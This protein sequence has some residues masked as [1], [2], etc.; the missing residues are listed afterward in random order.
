[1]AATMDLLDVAKCGV[2][3]D[4]Y[5]DPRMLSCGHTYCQ[6]CLDPTLHA[7]QGKNGKFFQ[8]PECREETMSAN[9]VLSCALLLRRCTS[10]CVAPIR[11]HQ[12]SLYDH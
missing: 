3:L 7:I 5:T 2:C 10:Y 11:T 9:A 4:L 8:C 12:A 6:A 1:M